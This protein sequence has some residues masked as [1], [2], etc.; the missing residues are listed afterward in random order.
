MIKGKEDITDEEFEKTLLPFYDNFNEYMINYVIPDTVAFYLA[1]S[2]YRDCLCDSP[3][4][5]H[6]NSAIDIFNVN[7]NIESLIPPIKQI[8]K[9]KFNLKIA[10]DN[11]LKIEKY[12]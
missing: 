1:N 6:I 10:N 2:H 9:I 7:C 4:Y 12:L 11:P 5:N 3:L 8:L